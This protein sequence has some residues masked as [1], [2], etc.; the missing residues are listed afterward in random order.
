MGKLQDFAVQLNG[1][2]IAGQGADGSFNKANDE[3][4]TKG[5]LAVYG[6]IEDK[7]QGTQTSIAMTINGN[8]RA[9]SQAFINSMGEGK[10]EGVSI[11][12]LM[13]QVVAD[14]LM[15]ALLKPDTKADL[16]QFVDTVIE[17]VTFSVPSLM[18]EG[19][20]ADEIKKLINCLVALSGADPEKRREQEEMADVILSAGALVSEIMNDTEDEEEGESNE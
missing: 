2:V 8:A 13:G 9:I 3:K 4:V 20:S 17:H 1:K 14:Q 6:E 11:Q 10:S 15:M 12:T 19:A 5:V 16:Q 18:S 7:G